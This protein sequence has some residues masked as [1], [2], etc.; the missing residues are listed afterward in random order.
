MLFITATSQTNHFFCTFA[1]QSPKSFEIQ[2]MQ[3]YFI[4]Y[5]YPLRRLSLLIVLFSTFLFHSCLLFAQTPSYPVKI[6][7]GVECIVYKVLPAE[8]FYRISKNFNTSET[9]I[10]EFNPHITDGLKAGMEIYIPVKQ[11]K[12]EEHNYIEHVVEK[13]QTIFRIR[14]MYNITED[15]L[16]EMNPHLKQN[17]LRTGEILKI[18]L[19]KKNNNIELKS[20]KKEETKLSDDKNQINQTVKQT[21]PEKNQIKKLADNNQYKKPDSLKIAFLLPLMLDQKQ[22]ASDRRFIEFYSGALIAIKQAKE[23]GIHFQIHTFDVEKSDLKIMEILQDSNLINMDLIV[24]P[25]FSNQISVVGDFARINKIK[26]LIPFSSKIFDLEINPYIYQFNPGQDTE[27]QKLQEFILSEG[28]DANYI[29]AELSHINPSDD[30]FV[31][32]RSMQQYLQSHDLPFYSLRL[33][34]DSLHH[35]RQVLNPMKENIIFFNTSRIN[36][37]SVYLRELKRLSE[38]VN[39]KIYEPYSWR[40]SKLEKPGSI[41]LSV[42]KDEYPASVYEQYMN[43]FTSLFHWTPT[44][45]LPRY[46]LLG[47]DLM[48]Y[49]IQEVMTNNSLPQ[50]AY[51]LKEGIQSNL[52]FEKISE[53]GG[54]INRFINHYE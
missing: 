49:F 15:E 11:Q 12:T 53:N 40:N 2:Y 32:F 16:I 47:Y 13:K 6:V 43:V 18:P 4:K 45:E 44:S 39:L 33:D 28:I 7:N 8:G 31:F 51:P 27:L 21:T 36:N 14:K 35:I 54:Y 30:S 17:K 46:D 50:K 37:V 9:E 41:Y 38:T 52:K 3:T 20:E 23:D 29:F 25:A 42:F 5:I 24:G 48:Q 10:R 34:P 1:Y 22:E 26:T 19:T